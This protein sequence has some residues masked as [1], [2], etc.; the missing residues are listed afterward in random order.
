V[1]ADLV[2]T[3]IAAAG[4]DP[5]SEIGPLDA[6]SLLPVLRGEPPDPR[7]LFWHFPH[8]TNQG[9]RPGGAVRDGRWKLITHYESETHQLFDLEADPGETTDVGGTHAE[10]VDELS[11]SHA[12]WRERIGAQECLPNP[13][14]DPAL[15]APLYEH[16]DVSLLAPLPHAGPAA[17]AERM[18]A[19]TRWRK[20]M[21]EA[22]RG[23]SA[24][25]TPARGDIRLEA[26]TARVHGAMLRYEPQPAKNTLGYWTNVDDWAEWSFEVPSAGNYEVEVLQGCGSGNGGSEVEVRVGPEPLRFV[27]TETGHFQHFIQRPIGLVTLPAGPATLD[28]KPSTKANAAVMDLRRV[29]LRPTTSI[30]RRIVAP[31]SSTPGR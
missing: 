5:A 19:L 9:G 2:P 16:L 3:L 8:Y 4:L 29:V 15:H 11:A 26:K 7:R 18:A 24:N 20:G 6:V 17:K 28:V 23:S 21:N 12:R 13:D 10:I 14:F 25:I 31:P 30:R 22:V 1:L 27:V